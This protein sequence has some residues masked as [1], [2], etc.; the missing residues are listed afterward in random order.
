M[1]VRSNPEESEHLAAELKKLRAEYEKLKRQLEVANKK[2]RKLPIEFKFKTAR[3]G[4]GQVLE[5]CNETTEKL[6]VAVKVFRPIG[7]ASQKFKRV[8]PELP[9]LKQDPTEIGHA[10][11]WAF[12]RG[13]EVEI[14]SDGFDPINVIVL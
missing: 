8:L 12:A 9:V 10:E 6:T 5:M 3:L 11:G 4:P 14:S 1:S 13:D 7:N 2:L